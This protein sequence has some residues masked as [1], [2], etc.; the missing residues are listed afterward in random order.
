[1]KKQKPRR[2]SL[3][4]H[5]KSLTDQPKKENNEQGPKVP[6]DVLANLPENIQ[7]AY[8]QAI[9]F[10]GPIP[11]PGLSLMKSCKDIRNNNSPFRGSSDKNDCP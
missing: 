1:M 5:N 6:S 8:T 11:P 10:N 4:P 7:M 9:S 2:Q 3:K